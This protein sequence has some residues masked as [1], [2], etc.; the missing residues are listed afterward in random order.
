MAA[1]LSLITNEIQTV[2]QRMSSNPSDYQLKYTCDLCSD[3][4]MEYIATKGVRVCGCRLTRIRESKLA[5]IPPKFAGVTLDNIQPRTDL[6]SKQAEI[7]EQ[8]KADPNKSYF[9]GGKF[10]TG[11]SV[12]MWTLYRHA[13]DTNRPKIVCCTLAELLNEFRAFIQAS[14]NRET[15]V[16]PR[17]NAADLRQNHTRY[18]IFLDD[19]DKAKPTEY[20][21]EQLFEIV[22]VIYEY[23][24]Q[25]VVTT[26][27]SVGGLLDHFDRADDRFGG[28]I[29]RRILDNASI[30]EL[31]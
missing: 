31:F 4:G 8:I 26:N 20:A 19:I 12:F 30:H 18:A 22:N 11:K 28:A 23:Q 3:T 6:H 13:V 7:V 2:T 9:F 14:V 15:P 21:A 10:G 1:T 29:V 27:L 16:I 25:L 17:L 24:H 5:A